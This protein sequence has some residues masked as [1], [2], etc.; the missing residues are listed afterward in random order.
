MIKEG[1]CPIPHSFGSCH[2]SCSIDSECLG[3][4]KCCYNGCGNECMKPIN[5]SRCVYNNRTYSVG[6]QMAKDDCTTCL[7]RGEGMAPDP[8]GFDCFT[9]ACLMAVCPPGMILKDVPGN[10]CGQCEGSLIWIID[11][12]YFLISIYANGYDIA[13]FTSFWMFLNWF[14]NHYIFIRCN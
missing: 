14:E 9:I 7:C 12:T 8:S 1:D 3:T 13:R 2:D 5:S 4:H 6:E 11:F 10:C